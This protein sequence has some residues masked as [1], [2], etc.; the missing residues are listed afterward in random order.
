M[1]E[2]SEDSAGERDGGAFILRRSSL[3]V[4]LF[5]SHRNLNPVAAP[6]RVIQTTRQKK[7]SGHF[8]DFSPQ[9]FRRPTRDTPSRSRR[10]RLDY[11]TGAWK[12]QRQLGR[13]EFA[14]NGVKTGGAGGER[15]A[16]M[17]PMLATSVAQSFNA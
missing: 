5:Q 13:M 7:Q 15:T 14:N 16:S 12:R 17:R 9:I 6:R 10:E 4:R 3:A 11:W 2:R 8:P 1:S